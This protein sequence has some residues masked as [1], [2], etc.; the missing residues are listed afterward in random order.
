MAAPRSAQGDFAR[1]ITQM[2]KRL[3]SLDRKKATGLLSVEKDKRSIPN[4]PTSVEYE[5]VQIGKEP[6]V[7][8]TWEPPTKNT[9]GTDLV[10]LWGYQ[11][12]QQIGLTV[13]WD[14]PDAVAPAKPDQSLNRLFDR[15]GRGDGWTGGDGG[16]SHRDE[17][18][19]DWWFWSDSTWGL[20]LIHI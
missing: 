16:A 1:Q 6:A 8:T 12:Q 19:K 11:I 15:R 18:G 14:E 20:S 7:V 5:S 17:S 3:N 4:P 10:D 2:E 9:D 13:S